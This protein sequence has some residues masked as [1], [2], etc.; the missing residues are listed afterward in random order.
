MANIFTVK[1]TA[2]REKSVIEKVKA[3]VKNDKLDIYALFNPK[4]IRG[5]F[6]AE[7]E[8]ED[9]VSE[10]IYNVRNAKNVVGTTEISELDKFLSPAPK[11]I[12]IHSGNKVEIT[13]GP[14]KG[15]EAKVKRVS[16]GKEEVVVELLDAAVPVPITIKI[17][18]VR[19]LRSEK[20]E[21]E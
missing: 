19:V 4:E 10:A 1:T 6:F 13:S 12:K 2:G 16:K 21:G 17:D 18:S 3:K 20:E 11:S 5:Y 14:F 8:S 7:A 9:N 15:E